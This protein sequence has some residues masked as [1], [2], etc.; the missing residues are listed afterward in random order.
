MKKI[1]MKLFGI[2]ELIAEQKETN[3]LLRRIL[4]ESVKY[5]RAYHI[6]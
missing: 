5:N 4:E 2:T 3:L 1:I 6:H